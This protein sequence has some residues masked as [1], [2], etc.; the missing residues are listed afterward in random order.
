ML[1]S[2]GGAMLE[3]KLTLREESISEVMVSY[4]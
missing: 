4:V 1:E 3:L 2:V